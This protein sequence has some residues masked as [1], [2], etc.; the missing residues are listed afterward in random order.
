M[1]GLPPLFEIVGCHCQAAD[2]GWNLRRLLNREGLREVFPEPA[3]QTACEIMNPW[4]PCSFWYVCRV[5]DLKDSC[6]NI[7]GQC[8]VCMFSPASRCLKRGCSPTWVP[9]LDDTT[10]ISRVRFWTLIPDDPCLFGVS[11]VSFLPCT[12]ET[13]GKRRSLPSGPA[14]RCWHW[15]EKVVEQR[16]FLYALSTRMTFCVTWHFPVPL[17]TAEIIANHWLLSVKKLWRFTQD[18]RLVSKHPGL[19]GIT[20]YQAGESEAM[21]RER[22]VAENNWRNYEFYANWIAGLLW[23]TYLNKVSRVYCIPSTIQVPY[24]FSRLASLDVFC[25]NY[26]DS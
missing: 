11:S 3:T 15:H 26:I 9:A 19:P 21:P 8:L 17:A 22:S 7:L 13:A 23:T 2:S 12:V 16:V 10:E 5:T 1:S 25:R 4:F 24:I 20:G 6:F 14:G 18:P